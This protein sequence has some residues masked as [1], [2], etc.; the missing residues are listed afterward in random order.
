MKQLNP[1]AA[2]SRKKLGDALVSL[3]LER[4]FENLTITAVRKRAKVGH[5]TF[6]RH[7]KS[8]DELLADALL[9]TIQELA[10]LL[11]QQETTYDATVALFRFIREHQDRF[12]VYVVLTNTHPLREI[13]KAEVVKIVVEHWEAKVTSPVPMDMSVDHLIESSYAFIRWYLNH[14]NDHTPEEVTDFYEDLILAGTEFTV[15]SRRK[16]QPD[17]HP[18]EHKD[19]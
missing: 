10:E 14:I 17:Q 11:R 18:V 15:L 8:L 5:V 19:D 9:T 4:G 7:Y 1:R 12:R 3:M 13:L 2:L 16:D 6:Y